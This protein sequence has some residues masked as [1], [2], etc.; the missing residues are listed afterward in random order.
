MH[1]DAGFDLVFLTKINRPKRRSLC[2]NFIALAASCR[3]LLRTN[4]DA[5][6]RADRLIARRRLRDTPLRY[7]WRGLAITSLFISEEDHSGNR[8]VSVRATPRFDVLAEAARRS[9]S[10]SPVKLFENIFTFGEQPVAHGHV[11]VLWEDSVFER[12][13][14]DRIRQCCFQTYAARSAL[15]SSQPRPTSLRA[16]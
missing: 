10:G 13:N 9:C 12:V 7:H 15:D 4:A 16:P 5:S 11:P 6:P 2:A 3:C 14:I 8:S 1:S